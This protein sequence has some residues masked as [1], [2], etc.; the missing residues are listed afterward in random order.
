MIDSFSI[1]LSLGPLAVYLLVIGSLQSARRPT[2]T[3][4]AQDTVALAI[5]VSGLLL[6]GPLVLFFPTM[7]YGMLGWIVW[8]MLA[9]FFILTVLLI[10]LTMRPRMVI[11]GAGAA[12]VREPLL[13]AAQSLDGNARFDGDQLTFPAVGTTVRLEV[14]A[15]GETPQVLP[16]SQTM[17]PIFWR[18][19]VRAT[20]LELAQVENPSR[21]KGAGLLLVALLMLA[22]VGS[23]IAT[24]PQEVVSGFREWLRL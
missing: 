17:S 7:A 14:F 20:R 10:V 1:T 5:G 2:V 23:Q 12:D 4:G 8:L 6:A 19:L 16:Q 13:R 22:F 11:Y 15:P 18:R 9:T 3:T 24:Q 21:G